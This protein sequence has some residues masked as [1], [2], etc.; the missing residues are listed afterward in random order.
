MVITPNTEELEKLRDNVKNYVIFTSFSKA[1]TTQKAAQKAFKAN[2]NSF[3]FQV[4]LPSMSGK[5]I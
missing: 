2:P 5:C 1:F 4:I 3:L